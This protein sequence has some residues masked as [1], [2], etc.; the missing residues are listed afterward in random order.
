MFL[1]FMAVILILAIPTCGFASDPIAELELKIRSGGVKLEFDAEHGYLASLLR[2]LKIPVS[3]Q[4]LVF[5]KTSLQ[6]ERIS[7]E[8]P[9]ALYFNDDM[10]V[11]WAQGASLIEIMSVDPKTGAAFY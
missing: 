2:N 7:P 6:S 4:T 3:S 11:T 10:Y 9:R 5:S 1:R 8:R